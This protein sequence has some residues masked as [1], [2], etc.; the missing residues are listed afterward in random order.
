M[1]KSLKVAFGGII[2]A[3]SV[4]VM[5]FSGVIP[6]TEYAFPLFAG[7]L[8]IP[9]AEEISEKWAWLVFV[10]VS[11]LAFILVP[12]RDPTVIYV[13]LLG[14]Y[15]L[16]K[17]KIER[18]K[19]RPIAY[20]VKFLLFNIATVASLL[21]LAF[22]FR[23]PMD[24]MNAYGKYTAVIFLVIANFFFAVYDICLNRVAYTYMKIF[25][26]QIS[27]YLK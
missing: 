5:F 14:Y 1:K 11:I 20:V 21:L 10:T 27:K 7:L 24:D 26:R 25:S 17:G 15:P 12:K 8:L 3:L 19:S 16:I 13:T 2:T 23:V 22:V 9:V 6:A 18:I 4:L